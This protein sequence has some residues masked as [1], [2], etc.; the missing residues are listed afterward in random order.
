MPRK[1]RPFVISR[2][3]TGARFD[4]IV[5]DFRQ[6]TRG[7]LDALLAHG[8]VVCLDEGGEAAR[9]ASFLID[10]IPGMPGGRV[11]NVS[12]PEYLDLPRRARRSVRMPP[13]RVMVSFGGEDLHGLSEKILSLLGR[14]GILTPASITVVE[15]P[16]FGARTW[17][18]S[19]RVLRHAGPLA[20]HLARC[21]LLVTH[22]G[23]TAF[24]GLARGV[25][26]VLLNPTPYHE[27]LGRS[28]GF[29]SLGTGRPVPSRLRRIVARPQQV[30]AQIEEFNSRLGS[31]RQGRL[32]SLLGNLAP[33]GAS[34]CPVCGRQGNEAIFRAVD[35]TYRR[36][37]DCGTIG[38]ETIGR[39]PVR[40]DAGYFSSEYRAQ[41]GR[42][43][44]Q[45]FESIKEAGRHRTA[46]LRGLLGA[47]VRGTVID[48]GCAYGPFL[49]ALAEA[50]L[51]GFGIDVSPGAVKWVRGRLGIPAVCA[52]FE[53]IGR[54]SLPRPVAAV[55]MWYVLEHFGDAG[56]VLRKAAS[57]LPAGGV[58]AFSTPNGRGI[59]A[60]RSLSDFLR[61]SPADHYSVIS[62][63][64]LDRLLSGFGLELRRVR[65][66]GH[67]P[68][69]FP[70]F[71]GRAAARWRVAH[72]FVLAMSRLFGLG[73]T[74][75]AYAVKEDS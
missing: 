53:T 34:A 35:R 48:V 49:V 6:T 70:G 64:G 14:T 43:Y 71:L 11:P 75:E 33:G 29:A 28:A 23:M 39:A 67:H 37:R 52:S 1:P 41:Y 68:E 63:R 40:Y 21:D 25:P 45:D 22:F 74:F 61:R 46:I 15:G 26:V 58:L 59:S 9:Y 56:R 65:V 38:K 31:R 30:T 13:R 27:R 32:A 44:L 8:P 3:P 60:R 12:S 73:D 47:D 54:A 50:G 24:E 7:E 17:P 62:P 51:P 18:A 10:T 69:R 42:T 55:T 4:L 36:C 16:L 72:S 66:T 20:A 2:I 57:L 5:V 19:V